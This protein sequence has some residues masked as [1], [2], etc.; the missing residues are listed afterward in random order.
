MNVKKIDPK[1]TKLVSDLPPA[2][3]KFVVD[4]AYEV[5]YS[6]NEAYVHGIAVTLHTNLTAALNEHEVLTGVKIST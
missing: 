4:T 3:A 5:S 1:I 2:L 6:D